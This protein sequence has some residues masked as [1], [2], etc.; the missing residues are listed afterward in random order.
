MKDFTLLTGDV[1]EQL[2]KLPAGSVHM[3]VFSPPY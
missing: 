1:N 2:G 3:A